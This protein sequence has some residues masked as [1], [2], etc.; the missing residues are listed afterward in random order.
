MV[1]PSSG[2]RLFAEWESLSP[3]IVPKIVTTYLFHIVVI[4]NKYMTFRSDTFRSRF[5]A[6]W[7]QERTEVKCEE[8]QN[9]TPSYKTRSMVKFMALFL[10]SQKGRGLICEGSQLG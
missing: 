7:L 9:D 4:I 5:L 6:L 1:P 2:L 3:H 10:R 8:C